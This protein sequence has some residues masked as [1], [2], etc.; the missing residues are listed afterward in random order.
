MPR[1]APFVGLRYDP[2][3]TGPLER[4]TA[5]P[6]DVISDAGRR[7]F[8]EASP[9]SIV[10]LDLAEGTDDP[11]DPESRY[12][13]AG[14]L[15][16]GWEEAGALVRDAEPRYYA[17]EMSFEREDVQH[18]VRGVLVA[19]DLEPWGAEVIPHERTLPGPVQDRLRLLRATGTHL[20]PVYGTIA[21]PCPPLADLLREVVSTPSTEETHDE[22]GVRHRL[23]TLPG[24]LDV[25]TWLRSE[26]LLIADG[27]HRYT[28]ALRYRAELDAAEGPG[29]W[30]RVLALVVDAAAE[31]LPVPPFH[32]IQ[33]AGSVERVGDPVRDLEVLLQTLS[34]D[35]M[36]VGL[37]TRAGET[38][39]YRVRRLRGDPPVVCELHDAVL[40]THVPDGG[41][42]FVPDPLVADAAVA[43]GEALAA[44]FLPS[45]TP[46]RIRKVIERG[47]RLPPKSTYFWPKPRTGMVLMPLIV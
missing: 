20:S 8:L 45:T 25:S 42:R 30:D 18:A 1:V 29:P 17:Y 13:H 24:D 14:Q 28:T 22:Q 3:V 23:W 36:T 34:D 47:Q 12:A 38:M 35:G 33:L 37:A 9:Y 43:D 44:W 26:P 2:A 41:L 7:G 32:R 11:A 4:V 31:K 5:P 46:D 39:E 19:L 6:Y 16:E 21:G 27:H 40:D 10:H 15:L